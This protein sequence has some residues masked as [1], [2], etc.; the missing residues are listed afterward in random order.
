[1]YANNGTKD[2]I[3]VHEILVS[4]AMDNKK[5]GAREGEDEDEMKMEKFYALLLRSI[6]FSY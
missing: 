5:R 3:E 4:V 2:N 1:M 6:Y